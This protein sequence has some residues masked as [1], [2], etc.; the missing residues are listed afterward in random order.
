LTCVINENF[1]QAVKDEIIL[2]FC[3]LAQVR[4][5]KLC[6]TADIKDLVFDKKKD[7]QSKGAHNWILTLRAGK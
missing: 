6:F 3:D 1:S 5:V 7:S 2:Q 4:P